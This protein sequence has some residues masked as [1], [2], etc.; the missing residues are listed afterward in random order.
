M[1]DHLTERERGEMY[2]LLSLL[3]A[4]AFGRPASGQLDL[5][6]EFE[7]FTSIN[8]ETG[9]IFVNS[10]V[11]EN[12]VK[13]LLEAEQDILAMQAEL[14]TL[15][16]EQIKFGDNYF[17]AYNEAKSYLRETRQELRK[18]ADRTVKDVRDLKGLLE[19]LDKTNNSPFLKLS[20]NKMRDLM[21]ETL[22]TLKK[23]RGLYNSAVNA[24]QNLNSSIK[25]QNKLIQNMV[26]EN[27]EEYDAWVSKVREGIY[28]SSAETTTGCII[29]DAIEALGISRPTICSVVNAAILSIP[30]LA[31]GIEGKIADQLEDIRRISE[32]MLQSGHNFDKTINVAIDVLIHEIELITVWTKSA[33]VVSDNIDNY[34]EEI[35]RVHKSVRKIFI[36]GLDDLKKA[37]DKF[38]SQP[39]DIFE[40][41]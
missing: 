24:F 1:G 22:E 37:A 5:G 35:L 12:V 6:A 31:F 19:G 28:G 2:L 29:T 13:M 25:I 9:N 40:L 20:I 7:I 8:N 18:L 17:L 21:I 33:K 10:T 36:D 39:I 3:V 30:Y 11:M 14:R 41:D 16:T 23:A 26:T 38:L 4:P 27:T 15:E 32:K 34:S